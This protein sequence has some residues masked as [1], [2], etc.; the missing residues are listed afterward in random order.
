M[1]RDSNVSLTTF[2]DYPTHRKFIAYKLGSSDPDVAFGD[3]VGAAYHGTHT[4]SST[5]GADD[6]INVQPRDGMAKDAKTYFIGISGSVLNNA[7]DTFADLNGL[8]L[9]AY[10]GYA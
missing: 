2:G 10:L 3:H 8:F 6:G 9:P 7:V 4:A 1:F 5:A